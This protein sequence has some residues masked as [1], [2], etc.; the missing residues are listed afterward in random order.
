MKKILNLTK[1]IIIIFLTNC[2]NNKLN[3]ADEI[4]LSKRER[5]SIYVVLQELYL[6]KNYKVAEIEIDKLKPT[7]GYDGTYYN[8]KAKI[9]FNCNKVSES[10][11][12][13]NSALKINKKNSVLWF[14]KSNCYLSLNHPDSALIFLDNA[15]KYDPENTGYIKAR[16][17]LYKSLG[18]NELQLSDIKRLIKLDTNNINFKSYLYSYFLE[19]NDTLLAIKGYES[20]LKKEPFN[21]NTLASLGFIYF[22]QKKYKL[23]KNYLNRQIATNPTD[24]EVFFVLGLIASKEKNK[25]KMCD[26]LLKSLEYGFNETGKHIFKCEEYL[27]KKGIEVR[28]DTIYKVEESEL[29][30]TNI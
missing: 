19:N 27:K 13:I 12:A 3:E 24:G 28:A 25:D 1:V 15:I 9:K 10:I 26:Y 7:D 6:K 8:F 11:F 2:C 14:L 23:A 17:M 22:R 20:I 29:K 5:D 30:S 16:S 4:I 21:S 18:M